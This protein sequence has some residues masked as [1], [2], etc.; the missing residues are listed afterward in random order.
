MLAY[1][2]HHVRL[3]TTYIYFGWAGASLIATVMKHRTPP[4]FQ[5]FRAVIRQHL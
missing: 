2:A 3:W 4:A 1:L 5:S